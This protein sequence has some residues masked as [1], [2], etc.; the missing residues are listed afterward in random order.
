M[1]RG[2][3]DDWTLNNY[4]SVERTVFIMFFNRETFSHIGPKYFAPDYN[5]NDKNEII[6]FKT[7]N[8]EYTMFLVPFFFFFKFNTSLNKRR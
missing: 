5:K 1:K 8:S 2:T 6:I 4:Y 7:H 3:K